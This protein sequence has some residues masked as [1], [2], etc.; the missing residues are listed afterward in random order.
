MLIP[1]MGE[2]KFYGDQGSE[3]VTDKSIQQ[4]KTVLKDELELVWRAMYT[5]PEDQSPWIYHRWLIATAK[6][7]PPAED[8][9]P[10]AVLEQELQNTLDLLQEEQ[11]AKWPLLTSVIL[12]KEL[13]KE[14]KYNK[15]VETN[16]QLLCEV[17]PDHVEYYKDLLKKFSSYFVFIFE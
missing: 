11:R 12:M 3:E 17:D 9:D 13:N 1:L 5:Q 7:I 10:Q 8:Y 16:I 6:K 14:G 2:K 15:H 4:L